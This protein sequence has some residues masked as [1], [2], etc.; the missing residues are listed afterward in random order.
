MDEG[1]GAQGQHFQLGAGAQRQVRH[2]RHVHLH[3]LQAVAVLHLHVAENSDDVRLNVFHDMCVKGSS[4]TSQSAMT[5]KGQNS[6]ASQTSTCMNGH[7]QGAWANKN[8]D[9]KEGLPVGA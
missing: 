3:R 8:I 2:G 5:T 7:V 9:A 1:G 4:I 6:V